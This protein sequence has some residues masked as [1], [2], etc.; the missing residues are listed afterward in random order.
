M[1]PWTTCK[2]NSLKVFT[3]VLG[4][5]LR[6]PTNRECLGIAEPHED[7][8]HPVPACFY[9]GAWHDCGCRVGVI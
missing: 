5:H 1:S 9:A 3:A 2:G 6:L 8:Y 4:R 7:S